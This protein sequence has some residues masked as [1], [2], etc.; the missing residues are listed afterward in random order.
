MQF[1]PSVNL[2]A[3]AHATSFT[4]GFVQ[5]PITGTLAITASIPLYDGGAR[6]A[7][8]KDS[9]S[10]IREETIRSRADLRPQPA[11]R[12]WAGARGRSSAAAPLAVRSSSN[13]STIIAWN[14]S[15]SGMTVSSASMPT[16]RRSR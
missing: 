12:I 4:S 8:L 16:K 13:A 7:A 3:S 11:A 9:A 1:A 10:K 5:D 14:A 2:V 15:T 6:Y